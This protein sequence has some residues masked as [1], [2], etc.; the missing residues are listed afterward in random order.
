VCS[1]VCLFG[2]SKISPNFLYTLLMAMA[3]SSSDGIAIR[4]VLLVLWMTSCFHIMGP[5]GGRP[6]Q[7]KVVEQLTSSILPKTPILSVT[8]D[9]YITMWHRE[10]SLLFIIALLKVAELTSQAEMF[11]FT[12]CSAIIAGLNED[13]LLLVIGCQIYKHLR[14]FVYMFTKLGNRHIHSLAAGYDV[15]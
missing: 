1:F 11:A 14:D 10:Q 13:C 6:R 5:M 4:Y 8:S 12:C 15:E 3:R 9:N 2:R 7:C